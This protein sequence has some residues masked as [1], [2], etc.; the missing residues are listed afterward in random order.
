MPG[1]SRAHIWRV[2]PNLLGDTRQL[3]A[4]VC[5]FKLVSAMAYS[6][7][8]R[9]QTTGGLTCKV[10]SDVSMCG[11]AMCDLCV[12][13]K[14]FHFRGLFFMEVS[15]CTRIREDAPEV[16]CHT[17]HDLMEA[18]GDVT[19]SR[20]NLDPY[21]TSVLSAQ[22]L[23]NRTMC[24]GASNEQAN[25]LLFLA[26]LSPFFFFFMPNDFVLYDYCKSRVL[27]NSDLL[28]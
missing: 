3:T 19:L 12:K 25:T 23:R 21:R 22:P 16:T 1:P 11:D 2:T 8:A 28:L 18:G 10:R 17:V 7:Q 9:R 27:C 5:R 24:S 20:F 26:V 4:S 15:I 6:V 13:V 14:R